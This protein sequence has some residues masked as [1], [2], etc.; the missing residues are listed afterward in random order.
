MISSKLLRHKVLF[1]VREKLDIQL[2]ILLRYNSHTIKRAHLQRVVRC[3]MSFD[4]C[5]HLCNLFSNKTWNISMTLG[6][7]LL[8]FP[9][10]PP[11]CSATT[12]P[13]T[14]GLFSLFYFSTFYFVLGYSQLTGGRNG[15]PLWYSSLGNSMD[16]GAWWVT[17]HGVTSVGHDWATEQQ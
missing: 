13:I 3:L 10:Q 1:R 8:L 6:S 16:R 2:S 15:N 9:S 7:S 14:R 11:P 5:V 12:T 17:D 4:G